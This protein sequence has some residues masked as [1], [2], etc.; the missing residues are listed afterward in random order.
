MWRVLGLTKSAT[1]TPQFGSVQGRSIRRWNSNDHK[2]PQ[3]WV[4]LVK[5]ELKTVQPEQLIWETAEV[6][7]SIYKTYKFVVLLS[8]FKTFF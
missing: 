3:E 8:T 2:F 7:F 4:D 6:R 5:K 1:R